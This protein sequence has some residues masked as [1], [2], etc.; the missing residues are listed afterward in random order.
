[1]LPLHELKQALEHDTAR[2]VPE[3][4]RLPDYPAARSLMRDGVNEALEAADVL[5]LQP[6]D[7]ATVCAKLTDAIAK[8]EAAR[9]SLAIYEGGDR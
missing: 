3:L 7:L 8:L 1:M 5:F 6:R 9:A 2:R 4:A